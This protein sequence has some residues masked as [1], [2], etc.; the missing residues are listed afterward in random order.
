MGSYPVVKFYSIITIKSIYPT[1]WSWH[2]AKYPFVEEENNIEHLTKNQSNHKQEASTD[3]SN[4]KLAPLNKTLWVVAQMV[5]ELLTA[6]D[7]RVQELGPYELITLRKRP[8]SVVFIYWYIKSYV[9][10]IYFS[11][12]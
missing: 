11:L 12:D 9:Q 5:E 3:G 6:F 1:I 7:I 10:I 2:G 4:K 8:K